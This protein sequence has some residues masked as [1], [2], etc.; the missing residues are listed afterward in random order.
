M[1]L[2]SFSEMGAE[3]GSNLNHALFKEKGLPR[4]N[5][6]DEF[7]ARNQLGEGLLEAAT[8]G[9]FMDAGF[10]G[11]GQVGALVQLIKVVS[12]HKLE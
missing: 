3:F 5:E 11:A 7:F 2:W 10:A 4:L 12:L 6:V 9:F 8:L 1:L